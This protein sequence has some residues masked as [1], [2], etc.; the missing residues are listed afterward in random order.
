MIKILI[1]I[2]QYVSFTKIN[3]REGDVMEFDRK[4][5]KNFVHYI[6]H[7]CKNPDYLGSTKLN[8]ILWYSDTEAYRLLEKPI[9]GETYKKQG[10]GPVPHHILG[11]LEELQDEGKMV[12][13]DVNF[14]K[15]DKKEFI[16]LENP[17]T[18]SFSQQ[19][20]DIIDRNISD[21]CINHTAKSISNKS[22][23]RIYELANQREE[24]PYEATLVATLGKINKDD[25]QWVK[26]IMEEK[27]SQ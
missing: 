15:Y 6:S 5:F 26:N 18:S 16:S 25:V 17:D 9:T 10:F 3:R 24:I 14:H 19:E 20:L 7:K 21:I 2:I 4:K 22:H 27:Y 13:N 11:V 8:K 1:K 23:D 12:V